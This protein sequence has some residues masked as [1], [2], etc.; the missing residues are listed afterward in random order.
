MASNSTR[1]LPPLDP[2]TAAESN[3]ETLLS[4]MGTFTFLA[5]LFVTLRLY[6]RMRLVKSVGL[7]DWLISIAMVSQAVH[8]L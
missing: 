6:A 2:A 5:L 4:V 8:V 1:T 3:T 7:D